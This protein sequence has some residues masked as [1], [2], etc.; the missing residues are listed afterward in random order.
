LHVSDKPTIMV[1][2]KVD[3]CDAA[4]AAALGARYEATPV[5][6]LQLETLPPLLA[7]IEAVLWPAQSDVAARAIARDEADHVSPSEDAPV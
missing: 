2:N 7:R 6:A 5:C 4:T 1:L 3:Q